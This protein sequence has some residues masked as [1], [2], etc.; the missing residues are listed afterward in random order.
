MRAGSRPVAARSSSTESGFSARKSSA[1]TTVRTRS[2]ESLRPAAASFSKGS[3]LL[4]LGHLDGGRLHLVEGRV[5]LRLLGRLE[6]RQLLGGAG[7]LP[8]REAAPRPAGGP[9]I[10]AARPAPPGL[11]LRLA[12]R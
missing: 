9:A 11:S 8:R 6:R 3:S 12:H 1:S 10:R 7:A 5:A 2:G 4:R